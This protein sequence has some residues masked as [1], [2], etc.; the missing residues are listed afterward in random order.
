MSIV[1]L[2]FTCHP[3]GGGG[4]GGPRY[5]LRADFGAIRACGRALGSIP[6]GLASASSHSALVSRGLCTVNTS[7][8]MS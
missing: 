3:Q 5:P 6:L 2:H 1:C 8:L 7:S 4:G